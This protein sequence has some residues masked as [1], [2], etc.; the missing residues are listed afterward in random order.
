MDYLEYYFKNFDNILYDKKSN[1]IKKKRQNNN[2][3]D[4][5]NFNS[6]INY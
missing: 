1:K 5:S 2:T 6:I 3:I 4:N